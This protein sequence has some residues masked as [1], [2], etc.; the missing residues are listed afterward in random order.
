MTRGWR[1]SATGVVLE[2]DAQFRVMKKLKLVG[3]PIKIHRHTA[4][5]QGMF[6]SQLEAAKFEGASVRTVSGIR[7]TIKKSVK[8]GGIQG[9]KEGSVRASFE[10]KILASD[11]VFL[12]A[13]VAVDVPHLFNPVTN[14]LCVSV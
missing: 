11:I 13:W 3:T 7:G 10:D 6:T 5:I 14:R 4:F 2:L 9:L 8:A 1:I 12:R